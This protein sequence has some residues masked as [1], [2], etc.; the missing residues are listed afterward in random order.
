MWRAIPSRAAAADPRRLPRAVRP[1]RRPPA[2]SSSS[3]TDPRVQPSDREVDRYIQ[4]HENYRVEEHQVLH[5]K[6]VALADR[7]CHRV[8]EPGR[9]ERALDRD[10]P[11]EHKAEENA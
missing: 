8:P 4:Q 11:G 3:I 6:D 2:R 9:A 5:D 10:R 1:G 7:N